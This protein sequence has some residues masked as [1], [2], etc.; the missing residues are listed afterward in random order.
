MQIPLMLIAALRA[1]G[2]SQGQVAATAGI[3]EQR[4]SLL[5]RGYARPRAHERLALAMALSLDEADLFGATPAVDA[6]VA[7]M[8]AKRAK[9][10]AVASGDGENEAA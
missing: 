1:L 2:V 5:L 10:V 7:A 8:L 6:A 3:G 9:N 4:M